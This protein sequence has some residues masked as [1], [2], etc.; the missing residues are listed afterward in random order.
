MSYISPE[1]L[2]H[3]LWRISERIRSSVGP[4]RY[5]W[6]A[7]WWRVSAR[8]SAAP[9]QHLSYA[10]AQLALAKDMA[11]RPDHYRSKPSHRTDWEWSGLNLERRAA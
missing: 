4:A 6:T 8:I 10:S 9:A 7:V 2:V 11:A 5:F 1:T 3:R